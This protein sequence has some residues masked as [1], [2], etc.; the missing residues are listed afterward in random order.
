VKNYRSFLLVLMLMMALVVSAC[1]ASEPA[2]TEAPKVEEPKAEEPKAEEPKAEEPKAEEPAAGKKFEGTTIK[3]WFGS[4]GDEAGSYGELI[5]NFE[6][7]TGAVVEVVQAPQSATDNLSQQ[8]QFLGAGSSDLD[9]YQID[10]I[11]PGI[12][13]P[14]AVDLNEYIPRSEI[15]THFAA[16]IKN[17]TV[18]GKLVG[19][20]WYT[21]AGLLYYRTDLLEKYGY[22]TPPTT[23]DELEEM[24]ATIQDG[25]RADGNDS[26]WGYVWQGNNYEGLTCDA[27][28]WQYS[29]NGGSIIETDGTISINNANAMKAFERAATWVDTISPPGVTTYQE[30]EARG[31][32]QSGNAAF[33]RNWP[34]AFSLGNSDD[35]PIKGSFDATVLPTGAENHAATLGGWQLMVSKYSE[36]VDASVEFV[37]YIA[38]R[39][40]QKSRAITNSYLPTIG[41]LYKDQDVLK[42]QPF[43]GALFDVFNNA[44]ARPSTVTGELYN[45]VSAAYFNAVHSIL[46]GEDDAE[47]ALL[48]LEDKLVDITG[49]TPGTPPDANVEAMGGTLTGG[50][51]DTSFLTRDYE[52]ATIKVWFGSVGDEVGSYGQLIE[53]FTE[54]TG[55]EVEVV[56]APQ[57]ATDNLSQQ[58]QFLGAGSGDLDVYQIDVIWPGILAPHAVD[59]NEYIP[60]EEV[61]SHFAA[62]VGNNTVDGKLV[63][64]PWYTDAGLLYY[65]TDLLEKYG[66]DGPPETWDDLEEM[67]AT[68]QDGERADGNDSFWGWVWQGNNYEGLTCDALEWQVTEGGGNII[69]PDGT[70]TVNNPNAAAA[71]D[72]AAGWVDTISP[73]GV[74]TYQEEEGRGVWQSGNAAFMRNW[75]YAFSLGNTDDSP[76]KGLFDATTLPKGAGDRSAATL[77]GWQ[78]MVSKYSENIEA[79]AMFVRYIAGPEGQKSRAITNSYLPTIAG[80]YSDPELLDAQPFMGALYDVFTSAAARPSTVTGELYNEVSAAYFNAV[81]SILT[82]EDDSE[83]ALIDLEDKL[84]DITGFETGTP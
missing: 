39:E 24:A 55:I 54:Q 32:W 74:T 61:E 17:N 71:F 66:Y 29:H 72:R 45:E 10:V 7:E 63:G 46:T 21:D 62:I 80:L 44:V 30:E 13:A 1:S 8:L 14:H 70:I 31:V 25:E 56:Q 6:A 76:I 83:N 69:E 79:S 58:L 43:M 16:I 18:D 49:F 35:S 68:I 50:S 3:V 26:F 77:G 40:G 64:L 34:Y 28:E 11:W 75:P 2:P 23:W 15:D 60:T 37:R 57:S 12:L 38:G 42:A 82:G 65:R 48:D 47:N 5:A 22:S 51:S 41:S 78:L 59:L 33:M 4:V 27:L 19:L 20:P 81:H 52:G 36:N 53:N 67:A 84:I 73:P 9:V